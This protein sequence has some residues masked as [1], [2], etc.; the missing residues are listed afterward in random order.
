MTRGLWK[1]RNEVVHSYTFT[2]PNQIFSK[3]KNDLWAYRQTLIPPRTLLVTSSNQS[4]SQWQKSLHGML[5]LNWD[6]ACN[7]REKRIGMGAIERNDSGQVL[8]SLRRLRAYHPDSFTVEAIALVE[9]I[10]FCS[11]ARLSNLMIEGDALWVINL[12]KCE[13]E[14]WSQGGALVS[15]AKLILNSFA[16]WIPKYVGRNGHQAAH[17]LARE[18]TNSNVTSLI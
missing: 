2:H 1:R 4:P 6:A 16:Y 15:E 7:S 8:G 11:N 14:D 13:S 9:A 17:I 18:A 10:Q 3:A 12:L 5:K